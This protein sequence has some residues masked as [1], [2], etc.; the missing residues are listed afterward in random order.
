MRACCHA[1]ILAQVTIT[2]HSKVR[3]MYGHVWNELMT[4]FLFG[5]SPL[6]YQKFASVE[7]CHNEQRFKHILADMHMNK[8]KS[9]LPLKICIHSLYPVT[10]T[11][12]MPQSLLGFTCPPL[13]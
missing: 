8:K 11:P 10:E 9:I 3:H 2:L 4:G 6:A 5:C 13:S 7:Q 12:S 1:Q